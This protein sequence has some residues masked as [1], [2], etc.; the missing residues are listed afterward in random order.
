MGDDNVRAEAAAPRTL[1]LCFDGTAGQFDSD[2]STS[3]LL[4]IDSERFPEYECGQV[5]F[6]SLQRRCR[7][8]A[9]LLPGL[10]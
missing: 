7:S 6:S 2:V 3:N 10:F 9:M 8:P 5:I 1:V 4:L